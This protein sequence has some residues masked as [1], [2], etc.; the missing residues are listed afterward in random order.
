MW[1]WAEETQI[2]RKGLKK[3]LLLSKDKN[4]YTMWQRAAERGSLEALDALWYWAKEGKLN[5]VEM[6]LAQTVDGYTV[7]QLAAD[8]SHV[9]TLN[10][11]WIWAEEMQITPKS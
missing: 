11:L 10:K 1:V 6:L 2:N 3:I 8:N 4:G 5:T 9:E 7:F